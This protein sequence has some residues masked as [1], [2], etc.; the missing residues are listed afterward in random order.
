MCV[1]SLCKG[2]IQGIC[3]FIFW[4]QAFI[5]YYSSVKQ[6][7]TYTMYINILYYNISIFQDTYLQRFI[8]G[9]IKIIKTIKIIILFWKKHVFFNSMIDTIKILKTITYLI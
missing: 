6:K 8:C 7:D 4:A 1:C 5:V 9:Y 2:G 3:I